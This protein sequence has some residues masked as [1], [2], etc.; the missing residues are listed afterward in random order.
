ML[1][2]SLT[3]SFESGLVDLAIALYDI[4]RASGTVD[5]SGDLPC[6]LIPAHHGGARVEV[7]NKGDGLVVGHCKAIGKCLIVKCFA[8]LLKNGLPSFFQMVK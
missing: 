1:A 4:N 6:A 3:L 2:E 5:K 8:P 7:L